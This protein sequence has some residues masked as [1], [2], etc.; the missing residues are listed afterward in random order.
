MSF[1]SIMQV[2]FEKADAFAEVSRARPGWDVTMA[3]MTQRRTALITGV[4]RRRGIGAAIAR[5]LAADGWDLALS[6]WHP[7]DDRIGLERQPDDVDTLA[8][9]LRRLGRRVE[10]VPADLEDPDAAHGL[11]R[12]PANWL[13]RSPGSY[14]RTASRSTRGI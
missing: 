11:L 5:G 6:Y 1:S 4:G 12:R 7:Y 2:T 13:G 8:A 14:S 9:E 10:L 3:A